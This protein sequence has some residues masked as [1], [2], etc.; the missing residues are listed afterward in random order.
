MLEIH[1]W[2]AQIEAP[3]QPDRVTI[4]LDPAQDVAW[5]S[6]IE[7]AGEVRERLRR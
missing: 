6:L 5:P 1:L 7:A 2:G 3:E 4:D